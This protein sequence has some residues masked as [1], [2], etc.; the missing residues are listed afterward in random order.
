MTL[1]SV[2]SR[3]SSVSDY[4]SLIVFYYPLGEFNIPDISHKYSH[5][6]EIQRPKDHHLSK[7]LRFFNLPWVTEAFDRGPPFLVVIGA[8][9]NLP[10]LRFKSTFSMFL[11]ILNKTLCFYVNVH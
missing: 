3:S 2:T 8:A 1:T 10:V 6:T 11:G 4:G 7:S 9:K 5:L